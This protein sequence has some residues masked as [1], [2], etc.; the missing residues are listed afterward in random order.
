MDCRVLQVGCS[1]SEL[2]QAD[3][4]SGEKSNFGAECYK[5]FLSTPNHL[6]INGRYERTGIS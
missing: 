5:I 1:V 4:S 6:G 3:C 2:P